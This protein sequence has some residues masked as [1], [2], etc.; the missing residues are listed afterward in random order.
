MLTPTSRPLR[1]E[2]DPAADRS[3]LALQWVIAGSA[4]VAAVLLALLS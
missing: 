1:D 3:M 4:A 2:P